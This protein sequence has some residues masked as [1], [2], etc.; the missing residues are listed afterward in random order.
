MCGIC[1]LVAPSGPA[2][3][4]ALER[5]N[6]ALVHRGPDDGSVDVFGR[7]A[8]GHRRLRVLDL[9]TGGQPVA[10]EDGRVVAVFNGELYNFRELRRQLAARGHQVAGTGDTA[11]IPH[12]YEE[13]GPSF[14]RRLHGMFAIA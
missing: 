6:A 12:L 11:V 5:V 4:T 13:D 8:L 10:S 2:D 9:Q 7:C 3:A 1:G 14:V